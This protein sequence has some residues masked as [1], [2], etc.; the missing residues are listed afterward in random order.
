MRAVDSCGC[1]VANSPPRAACD[2]ARASVDHLLGQHALVERRVARR[3]RRSCGMP[4]PES[5]CT[6]AATDRAGS[7][8]GRAA[9]AGSSRSVR[10]ISSSSVRTPS[11]ASH[12]AHFL[13]DEAE[14]VHHHLGQADEMLARRRSSCVATPVAQ[15]FRWQMRRYLQP[16]ATIGAVPKPKLSAPRM[17]RLDHV[18]AGLQAAV[19][20][21]AHLAAQVVGAQRLLRLGQAQLPRR[22]GVL[23]RGRAGSRRCRRRSRRW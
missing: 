14:I 17:R 16:S 5:R 18:E 3:L 13:G 12:L 20:L 8:R 2:G 15:L 19:G 9:G 21:H 1:C 10:P 22:A 4:A 11:C 23:D 7:A 6:A